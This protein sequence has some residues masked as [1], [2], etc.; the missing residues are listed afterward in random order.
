MS[1]LHKGHSHRLHQRA[2]TCVAGFQC[3]KLRLQT[4]EVQSK[5]LNIDH[6]YWDMEGS[7]MGS[8]PMHCVRFKRF[9][10]SSVHKKCQ[11]MITFWRNLVVKKFHQSVFCTCTAAEPSTLKP[12]V[13]HTWII[14]LFQ[15]SGQA[16]FTFR[17]LSVSL[18]KELTS[19]LLDRT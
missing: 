12:A 4:H 1:S 17:L 16:C 3:V 14:C 10:F 15:D 8:N 5:E 13:L 6:E 2:P 9:F 7:M 11:E 18:A 19:R